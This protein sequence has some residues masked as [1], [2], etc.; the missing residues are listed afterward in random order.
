MEPQKFTTWFKPVRPVSIVDSTLT[1]EVPSDF[2]R[3]YLEATYLDV[4]KKTLKRVI[5]SDAKLVYLVR[6][7]RT[8][9]AL[10][11]PEA[12]GTTPVNREVSI[13]VQPTGNPNPFVYPGLHK[14]Q[15]DPKLNPVTRWAIRPAPQSPP[16]PERLRSIPCSFSAAPDL[17]KRIW[18]R[19]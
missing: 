14:I 12:T 6:A 18:H 8:Q 3:E 16:P 9:P 4:I 15:I 5:G 17:A 7:V 2:F 1:V 13:N 19:L 11:V 10:A